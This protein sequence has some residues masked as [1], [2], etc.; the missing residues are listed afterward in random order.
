MGLLWASSR[1]LV[2]LG[3]PSL[4]VQPP[5]GPAAEDGGLRARLPGG[6]MVRAPHLCTYCR[7]SAPVSTEVLTPGCLCRP[8]CFCPSESFWDPCIP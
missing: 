2:L 6:V 4:P 3:L 7:L 1:L 8:A 5:P